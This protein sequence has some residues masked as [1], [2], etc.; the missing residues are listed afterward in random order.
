MQTLEEIMPA[1]NLFFALRARPKLTAPRTPFT[2]AS[3]LV[4]V[5]VDLRRS[6]AGCHSPTAPL[7]TAP[8]GNA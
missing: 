4:R 8:H 5:A 3:S 6:A 2:E 7:T 1:V